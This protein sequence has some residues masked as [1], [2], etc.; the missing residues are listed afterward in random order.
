M[1]SE[2]VPV[3]LNLFKKKKKDTVVFGMDPLDFETSPI[4]PFRCERINRAA[5]EKEERLSQR[6]KKEGCFDKLKKQ[7][8]QKDDLES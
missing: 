5:R 6:N 7:F 8:F 3:I 4:N 2:A 1:N